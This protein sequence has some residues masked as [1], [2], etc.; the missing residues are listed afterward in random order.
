MSA[1][2]LVGLRVVCDLLR[3]GDAQRAVR[4]VANDVL[5]SAHDLCGFSAVDRI[6]VRV[7]RQAAFTG[8]RQDGGEALHRCGVCDRSA[9]PFD[10]AIGPEIELE[11]PTV[12][13][14]NDVAVRAKAGPRSIEFRFSVDQLIQ[15]R[16]VLLGSHTPDARR[17]R[18]WN[19]LDAPGKRPEEQIVID[20]VPLVGIEVGTETAF[21]AHDPR[22]FAHDPVGELQP[23]DNP[24]MVGVFGGH[25]LQRDLRPDAL[26]DPGVDFIDRTQVVQRE[27]ALGVCLAVTVHTVLRKKRLCK[28]GIGL[29][30]FLARRVRLAIGHRQQARRERDRENDFCQVHTSSSLRGPVLASNFLAS[31][32]FMLKRSHFT[33]AARRRDV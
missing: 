11:F 22:Q 31:L 29:V 7:V 18:G 8:R 20:V 3:L 26:P 13:G 33:P 32:S 9:L 15:T 4:H 10:D 27:F 16:D 25:L 24:G 19:Q 17:R 5:G 21:G 28:A 12:V 6:E 2:H 14:R 30:D 23:I 1:H